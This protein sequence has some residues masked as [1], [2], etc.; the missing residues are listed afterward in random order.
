[1]TRPEWLTHFP[2]LENI[3]DPEWLALLD[4]VQLVTLP[5]EVSVFHSGD[6]CSNFLLVIDGSV[7]VQKLAENGREIVLYRI[8]E[9]QS[10]ILTTAC[11]LGGG[12]YQAEAFTETTVHAVV[13]PNSSFQ[14]MLEHSGEF[15]G[16]VFGSYAQR[17]TDLLMLIEAIS[18]G[19]IDVRLA[20]H[21]LNSADSTG[22]LHTTHQEL[23]RDL[24]SA[25]EVISRMLKEFERQGLVELG[26]GRISLLDRDALSQAA[27]M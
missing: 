18:F 23:A 24:G 2:P 16:F 19:R 5:A 11:L 1:M 4:T 27:Q 13:L 3:D 15:R 12:A 26:R 20:S 22:I 10:C 14:K 9:G 17:I 7:R 25:R 21:L 6:R 8:E